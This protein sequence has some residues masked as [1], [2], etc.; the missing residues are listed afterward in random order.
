MNTRT[1]LTSALA[2]FLTGCAVQPTAAQVAEQQRIVETMPVCAGEDDCRVKWE[3]AQLWVTRNA[4]FKI[5]VATSVLIET[6]NPTDYSPRLA[7]RLTKEPMGGGRYR[8]RLE[9]WCANLFG[10]SPTPAS[11]TLAFNYQIGNVTP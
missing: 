6:Y 2:I 4:G 8:L 10:C 9:A 1:T 7:M 11:A 3:A 5:Q